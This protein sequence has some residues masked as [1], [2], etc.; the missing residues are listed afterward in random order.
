MVLKYLTL[1][2][3]SVLYGLGVSVRNR[4][5]NLGI[6]ETHEFDI[7]IICVGNIT[8]GGTGKTPHT[9][10][11]INVL[12]NDYRVACLSRGYKRKT[13]GF[14]LATEQSTASEIGDEPMQIKNKFP[15]ITV[16]VDANRVR[17]IKKLMQ[18][19][20][21]PD[22]IILDDGFQHRYVKADINILLIDYNRPLY[23]DSLLP[24]GRLREKQ[25]AKDR[26]NYVI[27]TKC[28]ANISPIEKRIISKHLNL[29]AYQQ[30][31]FTTMKYGNITPLDTSSRCSITPDCAILCVTGIAQPAPYIEHLEK[32]TN[33]IH[34]VS[35]PDHHNYRET[36]IQRITQEYNKIGNPNKYIFTT[37]KDAVRLALCNIPDEIRQRIFYV[38]IEPEFLTS[39]DQLIKNIYN[40]VR[41]DKRK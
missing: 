3:L 15:D 40:Y 10:A 30:L 25:S 18:L 4:L 23:E 1:W 38:P 33:Q 7:P 32:L 11:L 19:P 12:K 34:H 20:E 31:L 41:Q 2:P 9:E 26:A 5:F 35:F 36:D 37:E 8:V 22:V 27:V 14:V 29:M 28:P 17:G 6:L 21:K 16:A 24:L 39:Q 13:S